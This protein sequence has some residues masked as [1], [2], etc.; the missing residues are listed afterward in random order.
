MLN[1]VIVM[2][3]PAG[4]GSSTNTVTGTDA[5]DQ[6]SNVHTFQASYQPDTMN[7]PPFL[8]AVVAH[9]TPGTPVSFTLTSTDLE[10]DP[11]VYSASEADT[12]AP[13]PDLQRSRQLTPSRRL[14]EIQP[15]AVA[16]ATS[17]QTL[18]VVMQPIR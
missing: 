12:L 14:R 16:T 8:G 7:D 9:A 5:V 11:V 6:T 18:A 2:N 4:G 3:A 17:V 15:A 10:N 1:T 13:T